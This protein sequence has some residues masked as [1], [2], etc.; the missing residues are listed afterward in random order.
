MKLEDLPVELLAAILDFEVAAGPIELW[1]S[2]CTAIR[3]KLANGGVLRVDLRAL[4]VLEAVK[5]P[6]CLRN[7]KLRQLSFDALGF[8]DYRGP[9][10]EELNLL[11]SGLI[12][13]EICH[14]GS[15]DVI[16]GQDPQVIRTRRMKRRYSGP[17]DANIEEDT[18]CPEE[19][20][21]SF[22]F[23]AHF[24]R[25]EHLKIGG[26]PKSPFMA[27]SR[28]FA[29]LPRSLTSL[30]F[31]GGESL[32]DLSRFPNLPPN[33]VIFKLPRY[34]IDTQLIHCLP[35][36]LEDVGYCFTYDA[37]KLLWKEP[38]I[39]PNLKRFPF[40]GNLTVEDPWR[41]K[42]CPQRARAHDDYQRELRFSQYDS[43]RYCIELPKFL[44]RLDIESSYGCNLDHQWI[45]TVLPRT[46]ER[47]CCDNIDWK[48]VEANDWPKGLT[49]LKLNDATTADWRDLVKLPRS[50]KKL[51]IRLSLFGYDKE[52]EELDD[53]RF[54][55]LLQNGRA[56]LSL[57][58]GKWSDLRQKLLALG[59]SDGGRSRSAVERLIKE[60]ENGRLLGLP[61]GLE[62]LEL[63]GDLYEHS[64]SMSIT[65]PPFVR[66]I[67][68]SCLP[69][70]QNF[71]DRFPPSVTAL[72]L[73]ES[74]HDWFALEGEKT[75]QASYQNF[76]A[77]ELNEDD[78]EIEDETDLALEIQE[79]ERSKVHFRDLALTSVTLN[80]FDAQIV[81]ELLLALP[82]SLR[83]LEW[84]NAAGDLDSVDWT[85][86]PTSLRK[87]VCRTYN[88]N[89][90]PIPSWHDAFASTQLKYATFNYKNIYMQL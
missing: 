56:S 79:T 7:F 60:I 53:D 19:S 15:F 45:S 20:D 80:D 40:D 48:E 43:E 76:F 85:N 39:L 34:S 86:M 10:Q 58:S 59:E 64:E 16:F 89:D 61:L 1:K 49:T 46:L 87:F 41:G 90:P 44:I 77:D 35:K 50:L 22:N 42:P 21:V 68:M 29:R 83:S 36:Q 18:D 28:F 73:H 9:P 6:H 66:V 4:Q 72:R 30:D 51:I 3:A 13:L 47:L 63:P 70:H 65:F 23:G 12:S 78:M 24:E 37:L 74:Q 52:N 31:T 81:L 69:E 82:P 88:F 75:P 14:H 25:L 54:A 26:N 17:K 8:V 84:L 5:W 11:P 67:G 57:E 27:T 55:T 71:V 32:Q 38:H 62:H 33:L 2:G